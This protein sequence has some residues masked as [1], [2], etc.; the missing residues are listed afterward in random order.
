[1]SIANLHCVLLIYLIESLIS[2]GCSYEFNVVYVQREKSQCICYNITSYGV[3]FQ[4][5]KEKKVRDNSV[6]YFLF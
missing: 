6:Y 5:Q 4:E 1:M 2:P 3:Y